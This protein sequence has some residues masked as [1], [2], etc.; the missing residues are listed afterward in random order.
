MVG[1]MPLWEWEKVG[2][3]PAWSEKF[4]HGW[5]KEICSRLTPSEVLYGNRL[6]QETGVLQWN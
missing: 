5:K 3:I 6:F 4:R 1:K 2:K